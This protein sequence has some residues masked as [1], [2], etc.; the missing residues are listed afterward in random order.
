VLQLQSDR[1]GALCSGMTT[2]DPLLIHCVSR[3]LNRC[4]VPSQISEDMV[5]RMKGRDHLSAAH[6]LTRTHSLIHIDYYSF[7]SSTLD[8]YSPHLLSSPL[9]SSHSRVIT[10]HSHLHSTL[11]CSRALL[12]MGSQS[13]SPP[14]ALH[15]PPPKTPFGQEAKQST[16]HITVSISDA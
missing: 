2:M 6:S 5:W 1:E 15:S 10:H 11:N 8:L 13:R 14:L 12:S 7:H 4:L 9:P 3:S 16:F